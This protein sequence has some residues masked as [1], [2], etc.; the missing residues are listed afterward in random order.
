MSFMFSIG[1]LCKDGETVDTSEIPFEEFL[2]AVKGMEELRFL[3]GDNADEE[4]SLVEVFLPEEPGW[5]SDGTWETIFEWS[6]SGIE[7]PSAGDWDP[8]EP[9]WTAAVKLAEK[10]NAVIIDEEYNLYDFKSGQISKT[11]EEVEK[12]VLPKK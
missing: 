2:T 9:I 8:S 3:D 6:E 11:S 12:M 5:E 1:R 4:S 7:F 10:L